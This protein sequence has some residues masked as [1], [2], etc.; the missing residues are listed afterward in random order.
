[1]ENLNID[2]GIT[3]KEHWQQATGDPVDPLSPSTTY[4]AYFEKHLPKCK[5]WT[6][7]EVG[8]CPGT[9][10]LA[11]AQS[12]GYKP[13]ALDYISEVHRLPEE[14]R[15]FGIDNLEVIEADFL[16]METD[17]RFN[18]VMSFGFLEHFE[19]PSDILRRHWNLVAPGGFLFVG[20]PIFGPLQMLLRRFVLTPEKLAWTLGAHNQ[21]IMNLKTLRNLC[22][23]MPDCST[24]VF[25]SHVRE[26]EMWFS[27]S[28]SYVRPGR[29][30]FL[31]L[32]KICAL[33]PKW[34]HVSSGLFSPYALV[35][36]RRQ[37]NGGQEV[38]AT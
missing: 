31:Y 24:V 2:T 15:K 16:K 35:I 10:L 21:E 23:A 26:M 7:L 17:R 18:I 22:A 37:P 28:N 38:L 9:H 36:V 32:W 33:L 3:T 29:A 14:F 20:V 6:V 8:A 19:N 11:I 27:P 13:V 1:M 5:D 25:A 34:L 4:R 12:H 30:W